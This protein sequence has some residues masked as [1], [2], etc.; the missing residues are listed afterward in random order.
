M[1]W[2]WGYLL[3]VFE[4]LKLAWG[5]ESRVIAVYGNMSLGGEKLA[6]SSSAPPSCRLGYPRHRNERVTG[7]SGIAGDLFIRAVSH[8]IIAELMHHA[9]C[10]NLL[11]VHRYAKDDSLPKYPALSFSLNYRALP[12]LPRHPLMHLGQRRTCRNSSS[13]LHRNEMTFV[14][15]RWGYSALQCGGVGVTVRYS[16]VGLG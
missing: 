15:D 12:R 5:V 8:P 10:L 9:S 11:Q 1:R 3:V 13:F 6:G 14:A 2:D 4:S 7:F 16:A